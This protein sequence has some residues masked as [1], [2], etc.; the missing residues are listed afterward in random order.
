MMKTIR[1][2]LIL[3]VTL[4]VM[5]PAQ[6]QFN[7]VGT[8]A[9]NFLKIP[10]GARGVGLGGAYVGIVDDASSLF[11]NVAGMANVVGHEVTFQT[12]YWLLDLRLDYLAGVFSLSDYDRL[13]ISIS[14]LSMGEM[15]QTSPA[16][17][18]GTGLKFNAYD[19]AMGIAYARQITDRIA[20][21]I[22]AKYVREVISKS[23]A[24]GLAFDVGIQYRGEWKNLR[25]GAAITNFGPDLRMEG[26]DL[27]VKLDPY[28]TTGTNPE[29][30]PLFLE[31]EPF[32]LP[33]QFQFG[34]AIT[35]YESESLSLTTILDVRDARD[36]NQE[37][38]LGG[39]LSVLNIFYLRGGANLFMVEGS[40]F[41]K[42]SDVVIEGQQ[43][44]GP[45][46][47]GSAYVNPTTIT[48]GDLRDGQPLFNIGAGV[49]YL[50][51][52]SGLSFRFDY[53]FSRVRTLEDVHR[54]GV[55]LS[56]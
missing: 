34:V 36:F 30:V 39:E 33:I 21:G 25:M 17:P 45:G 56:F 31:T 48:R 29:D 44:G 4:S 9:A 46:T 53:A 12:N 22:H 28:P 8:S 55:T 27:R 7:N 20:L 49:K 5:L 54:F 16:Q 38:R 26:E 6:A 11:W 1:L 10:I 50:L 43:G 14:Y 42:S 3:A 51:P 13:G 18:Q 47:V 52:T 2:C 15:D 23:A 37:I 35:P 32:S 41:G 19:V 24:S 40:I